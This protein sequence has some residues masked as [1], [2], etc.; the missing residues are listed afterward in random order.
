MIFRKTI[1]QIK[2][3]P[4]I[5]TIIPLRGA[6]L[7]PR[8]SLPLPLLEASHLPLLTNST[9]EPHVV[10]LVQ[11]VHSQKEIDTNID[12][13]SAGTAAQITDIEE[14]EDGNCTAHLTGIC[15]FDVIEEMET[16]GPFR[17]AKV[18]YRRYENDLVQESDFAID[19]HRLIKA[20]APYFQSLDV[21][22]NWEEIHRISNEK[23]I[24]TLTLVCPFDPSEKQAVLELPT[25]KEQS[26]MITTL[27]EMATVNPVYQ[28]YSWH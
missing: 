23:L 25:V 26:Q 20:L 16:E 19:R 28:S 15:R 4:E 17:R 12:L 14:A 6:V 21:I 7:L 8:A 5:L 3:L 9:Q 10:G 27:I 13:F 22:P 2:E 11:P 1:N 24:N 18:S